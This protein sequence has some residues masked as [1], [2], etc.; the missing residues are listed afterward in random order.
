MKALPT[1]SSPERQELIADSADIDRN[2]AE[3]E[4]ATRP[5]VQ[6]EVEVAGLIGK[7]IA[8]GHRLRVR[9]PGSV[10]FRRSQSIHPSH[11][12]LHHGTATGG[13]TPKMRTTVP[14]ATATCLREQAARRP[15][16]ARPRLDGLCF[17]E[18]LT[19]AEDVR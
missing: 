7:D 8:I 3:H 5:A 4:V 12:P 15:P 2:R 6:R 1:E 9:C 13:A 14:G 17:R 16:A 19:R 10:A 11:R 18:P